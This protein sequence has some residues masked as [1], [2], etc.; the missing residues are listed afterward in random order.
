MKRKFIL[1][2]GE[3][4]KYF[5]ISY[6]TQKY[7]L[8]INCDCELHL[9]E[10]C[11][12]TDEKVLCAEESS[13]NLYGAAF[14]LI[15]GDTP[16]KS[17]CMIDKFELLDKYQSFWGNIYFSP[18]SID[19]NFDIVLTNPHVEYL[20]LENT[21]H[22]EYNEKGIS[23]KI[24][25]RYVITDFHDLYLLF[26]KKQITNIIF[27]VAKY[28]EERNQVR[29]V[30]F[31]R[32]W[33]A[34]EIDRVY[35]KETLPNG[36][37]YIYPAYLFSEKGVFHFIR[38]Q[39]FKK[40]TCLF[41]TNGMLHIA[42]VFYKVENYDF[43]LESE[44][45][46]DI[47]GKYLSFTVD[48]LTTEKNLGYE[49]EFYSENTYEKLFVST[50]FFRKNYYRN[51][52]VPKEATHLKLPNSIKFSE[53]RFTD[54]RERT[55][56]EKVLSQNSD[57]EISFYEKKGTIKKLL[58]TFPGFSDNG[59]L[60]TQFPITFSKSKEEEFYK[61]NFICFF[62]E[63]S[64]RG[65]YLQYD[66]NFQPLQEKIIKI[67]REKMKYYNCCEE[68]VVFFGSSKGASIC[69]MYL[70]AFNKSKFFLAVPQMNLLEYRQERPDNMALIIQ[71]VKRE[72]VDFIYELDELLIKGVEND[73]SIHLM[74]STDDASNSKLSLEYFKKDLLNINNTHIKHYDLQHGQ[75]VKQNY[76]DV[77]RILNDLIN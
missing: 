44:N 12:I 4:K 9:S 13:L 53:C 39:D 36:K 49:L 72:N 28:N 57:P 37:E 50:S 46:L 51:I 64:T 76:D 31:S 43:N 56:R 15:T 41:F 60:E 24:K 38:N 3:A 34:N 11:H 16:K 21:L 77:K 58:I 5:E 62:D 67:I 71:E 33:I 73:V 1:K 19:K 47:N 22:L 10:E 2:K 30:S 29:M 32:Y 63:N 17:L 26:P 52:I 69:T 59:K 42:N 74:L 54:K 35:I 18:Q 23:S 75:V 7:R 8:I 27:R 25:N 45:V 65:T 66:D 40:L 14:A 20:S 55:N 6:A 61:A 70:E 68:D 48:N